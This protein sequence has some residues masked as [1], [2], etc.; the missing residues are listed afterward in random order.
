MGSLYKSVL[1]AR[2]VK[3]LPGMHGIEIARG[4]Q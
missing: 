3:G 2:G 4:T 1:D